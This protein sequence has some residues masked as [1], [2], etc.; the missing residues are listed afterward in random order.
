MSKPRRRSRRNK[1]V[2]L[3][4]KTTTR[5]S[6]VV[7]EMVGRQNNQVPANALWRSYSK[8]VD[9]T[10]ADYTF[11]SKFRRGKATG[12]E[13]GGLFGRPIAEIITAW[14]FGPGLAFQIENDTVQ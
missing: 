13:L 8:T 10:Q 9:A 4:E 11:W 3:P 6:R 5:H 1:S 12:Y 7:G 2:A 14:M